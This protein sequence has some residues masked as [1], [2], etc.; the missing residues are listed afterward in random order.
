MVVWPVLNNG[1]L[2]NISQMGMEES[3]HDSGYSEEWVVAL[4]FSLQMVCMRGGGVC[5]VPGLVQSVPRSELFAIIVVC[6]FAI[7]SACLIIHT[8]GRERGRE[9]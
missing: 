7:Q 6:H 1:R 8:R 5:G 2:V 4:L 9:R 3:M